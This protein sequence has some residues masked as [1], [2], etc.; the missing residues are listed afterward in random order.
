MRLTAFATL[1]REGFGY[2]DAGAREG[3][4]PMLAEIAPLVHVVGFEPDAEECQ[5][6]N[7]A[8][9][10]WRSAT[11]LPWGLGA[12]DAERPFHLCR[13]RGA[14]SFYQPNKALLNR[15]PDAQRYEVTDTQTVRVR[16]LDG[17]RHDSSARMPSHIDFIKLDIQGAELDAL[18]GAQET[19]RQTVGV[20]VEVE[21]ASLYEGQP[22]F[23][24]VDAYL[25][26]RGFSLFKLRRKSWVRRN[27]Q[28]RPRVSAGQLIAGDAL[29]LRDPLAVGGNAAWPAHQVE[30]LVL[31]AVLY[32]LNDFALGVL[33]DPVLSQGIEAVAMARAIE[34]RSRPLN[35][36]GWHVMQE[37][38]KGRAGLGDLYAWNQRRSWGRADSDKDFYTRV[39][40]R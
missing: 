39:P 17:L 16:S 8:A 40:P 33:A 2:V 28:Q 6:L 27:G 1:Q 18:Q 36:R 3:V 10:D 34:Q 19:L 31:A 22:L 20:E 35:G 37:F 9:H 30:A 15:F 5:R 13:S 29:Y 7:A 38:F 14:S 23:R 32:D 12:R 26:E 21:F 4:H 24:D 25:A 11:Y